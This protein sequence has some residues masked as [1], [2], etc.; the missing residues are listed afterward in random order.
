MLQSKKAI[1][2]R[3]SSNREELFRGATPDLRN[4]EE[5]ATYALTTQ[6]IPYSYVFTSFKRRCAYEDE[7]QR[8]GGSAAHARNHAWRTRAVGALAPDARHV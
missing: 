8:Y 1:D 2:A 4:V 5:K 7:Q 3:A 6:Y